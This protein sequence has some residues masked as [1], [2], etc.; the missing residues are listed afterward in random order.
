MIPRNSLMIRVMAILLALNLAILSQ[1]AVAVQEP[2]G[3]I[4][5]DLQPTSGPPASDELWDLLFY[6]NA[7]DTVG[8]VLLLGA[9][10]AFGNFYV[11]GSGA[12]SGNPGDNKL[13]IFSPNGSFADSLPQPNIGSGWGWRDLA[14]DGTLLYAGCESPYILGFDSSGTIL[15]TIP[16]PAAVIAPRGLAYDPMTDHFWA[17]NLGHNIVEFDRNGN[18]IWQGPPGSGEVVYGMSWDSTNVLAPQ[19]WLYC[20]TGNPSTTFRQWDPITHSFTGLAH[21]VPLLPGCTSQIAGGCEMTREWIQNRWTMV[22]MAQGTPQDMFYVLDMDLSGMSSIM[23]TLVPFT[24]PVQIPASGGSFD[25]YAFITNNGPSSPS[26]DF[27]TDV[28]FPNGST[29][30]GPMLGPAEQII[31]PGTNTWFRYQEVPGDLPAGIYCYR[32]CMGLF[33]GMIWSQDSIMVEKLGARSAPGVS[34]WNYSPDGRA[35]M[36]ALSKESGSAVVPLSLEL[37]CRPNPFN[38]KT[39]L[40]YQLPVASFVNLTVYDISGRSVATVVDGWREAGSHEA[41]FD[42]SNLA[43]GIYVYRLE[44][45]NFSA[46]KKM[47]LMK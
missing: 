12:S 22:A 23:V 42:G 28:R 44:A 46:V 4:A 43:S 18:V 41:T 13:Y 20:Q 25:F 9:A 36:N 15:D 30:R 19:L 29:F 3:D 37:S 39:V 34:D 14:F 33:P 26:L 16:R 47:I 31:E 1:P 35:G 38:P 2:T 17:G 7:G 32:G 24:L 45:G 21:T 8:S 10:F 6:V 27:W 11:T 5:P 40:S